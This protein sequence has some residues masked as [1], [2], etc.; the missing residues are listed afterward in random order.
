MKQDNNIDKIFKDKFDSFSPKVNSQMWSNISNNIGNN[1]SSGAASTAAGSSIGTGTI[2]T[3]AVACGI[4]GAVIALLLNDSNIEKK[5]PSNNEA[6]QQINIVEQK[7]EVS[8]TIFSSSEPIDNNDPIIKLEKKKKEKTF[9]I[10]EVSSKQ[11]KKSNT[12]QPSSVVQLFLSEKQSTSNSSSKV[13]NKDEIQVETEKI[14]ILE[15]DNKELTTTISSSSSGGYV[16]LVVSFEQS[17]DVDNVHWD[18]GDGSEAAGKVVEHIFREADDYNVVV[19]IK[20]NKG[21]NASSNKII[22]VKS[23]CII[24]KI[25]NIFTPNSDGINDLFYVVGNNIKDYNIYIHNLS[26]E[27]VYK[28]NDINQGWNGVDLYGKIL[29]SGR[30]VYIIKAIGED[31]TDLSS[32]GIITISK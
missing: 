24:T 16:P 19:T 4:I 21:R 27:L 32:K 13:N 12:K 29:D 23:R 17:E 11:E 22:N 9:Q 10:K 18:F 7:N 2:I 26:G 3:I 5:I 20:D 1:L 31:G 8:E 14:E 25:P 28:S 6:K 15:I 30:Y